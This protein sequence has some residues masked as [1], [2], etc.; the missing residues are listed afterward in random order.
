MSKKWAVTAG[1][2]IF[3]ASCGQQIYRGARQ[4]SV[5][6]WLRKEKTSVTYGYDEDC[7]KDAKD[8]YE[9][10]AR[11]KK[12]DFPCLDAKKRRPLVDLE[13]NEDVGSLL[14]PVSPGTR[15][16]ANFL[17]KDRFWIADI[18]VDHITGAEFQLSWFEAPLNLPAAHA[19]MLFTF[20]VN[21]PVKLYDQIDPRRTPSDLLDT[22]MLSA[23]GA[24]EE[25]V[26]CDL[27]GGQ[28]GRF[29]IVYGLG[30]V[31]Q[32]YREIIRFNPK[33][34]VDGFPMSPERL[35]ELAAALHQY[36]SLSAENFKGLEARVDPEDFS[37]IAD[38]EVRAAAIEQKREALYA[39]AT[40][41]TLEHNCAT[42]L[43]DLMDQNRLSELQG[44]IGKAARSLSFYP[45]T[46][47]FLLELAHVITPKA[48]HRIDLEKAIETARSSASPR[49]PQ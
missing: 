15:R 3:F 32:R 24:G 26:T 49:E 21:H 41:R 34:T 44:L 17:H 37:F 19:Q 35:S 45:P 4:G 30:S 23:E 9:L 1:V 46:A 43:V 16:V 11:L 18:P 38:P 36:I 40:Y 22:L 31:E 27:V 14:G 48:K 13:Q 28:T 6:N 2:I 12:P 47:A 7:T 29:A 42:A 5:Q 10:R 25:G 33:R 8:P 20:N 39:S